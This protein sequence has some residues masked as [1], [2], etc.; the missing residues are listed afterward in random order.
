MLIKKIVFMCILATISFAEPIDLECKLSKNKFDAKH[1]DPLN[2]LMYFTID[3]DKKTVLAQ[4]MLGDIDTVRFLPSELIIMSMFNYSKNYT[5][6][7]VSGIVTKVWIERDTLKIHTITGLLESK[8]GED[9]K[10]TRWFEA[11]G[12][13]KIRSV[14]KKF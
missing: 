14:K 1:K 9:V 12:T 13:C 8:I 4:G 10:D 3:S 11:S 7:S 2:F 5:D 6:L